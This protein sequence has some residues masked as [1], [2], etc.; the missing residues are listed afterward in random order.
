MKPLFAARCARPDL[1]LA[2]THF[3]NKA[4]SWNRSHDR[5]LRRLMPYAQHARDLELLSELSSDDLKKAILV[6]FPDAGLA[7]DLELSKRKSGLCPEMRRVDDKKCWLF[8]W[9]SKWQG[10]TASSTCK[11]GKINLAT[12]LKSEV[13]PMREESLGR[14]VRLRFLFDNTQC[15]HVADT[16]YSAALR[17]LT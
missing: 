8:A 11:V 14:L 9:R 2:M 10:S 5:A 6:I 17:H 13:P 1:V 7:G 3:A 12:P 4:T 15:I 16:G